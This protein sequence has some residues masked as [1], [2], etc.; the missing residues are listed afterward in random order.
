MRFTCHIIIFFNISFIFFSTFILRLISIFAH[1]LYRNEVRYLPNST[2]PYCWNEVR[3]LETN[4]HKRKS[5]CVLIHC[6]LSIDIKWLYQWIANTH[7]CFTLM[8]V[9]YQHM[10]LIQYCEISLKLIHFK[11]LSQI[12]NLK[13]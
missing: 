9:R 13:N 10:D 5:L 2:A 11:I 6:F 8:C 4:T 7:K 3:T 1:P 12:K